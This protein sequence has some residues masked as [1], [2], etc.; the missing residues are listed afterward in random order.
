MRSLDREPRGEIEPTQKK[1]VGIVMGSDSDLEV[2]IG[3][4]DILTTLGVLSTIDFVSAHRTPDWLREYARTAKDRGLK[5]II[6]G[7][8]GAAHLPGMMAAQTRLPVIGVPIRSS[9]LNGLDSLLSEVQMPT[10]VP[11]GVMDINGAKN[12]ALYAVRQLAVEDEKLDA[13]LAEY[14]QKMGN[15]V[16]E[17]NQKLQSGP[18]EYLEWMRNQLDN[19]T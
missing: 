2:M 4:F 15:D 12:A 14:I 11:V 5:V 7:A 17:K 18:Y 13:R 10:G 9:H 8:G 19:K 16:I 1:F 6:A 3:A